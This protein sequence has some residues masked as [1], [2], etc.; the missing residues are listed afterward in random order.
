MIASPAS[1]ISAMATRHGRTVQREVAGDFYQVTLQ[2]MSTPVRLVF[3]ALRE[4][5]A[6][7]F[8]RAAL[9]WLAQFER[10]IR[11]SSPTVL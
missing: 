1:L 2:A 10:V 11:D 4:L 5:A 7:D 6:N 3:R 8:Q 9:E